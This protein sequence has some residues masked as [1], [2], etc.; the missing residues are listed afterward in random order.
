MNVEVVVASIAAI[1][2]GYK[3]VIKGP[4]RAMARLAPFPIPEDA[5]DAAAQNEAVEEQEGTDELAE[6]RSVTV[7][8]LWHC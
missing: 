3:Y 5:E 7:I 1:K 4:D 8:E 6:Y 2:Y